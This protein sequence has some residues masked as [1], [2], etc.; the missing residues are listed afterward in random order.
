MIGVGGD[1]DRDCAILKGGG[2]GRE[3][4]YSKDMCTVMR[5]VPRVHLQNFV[6]LAPNTRAASRKRAFSKHKHV[7]L[8]AFF[9][10]GGGQKAI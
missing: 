2:R 7:E 4:K 5:C 3:D 1:R 8:S 6:R 10:R 9:T